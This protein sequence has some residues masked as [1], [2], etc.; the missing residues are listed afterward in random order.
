V[1]IVVKVTL[2]RPAFHGMTRHGGVQW[3]PDPVR[4]LGALKSGAHALDASAPASAAHDVLN[5]L[6]EAPPPTITAP[7]HVLLDHPATYTDRTGLPERLSSTYEEKA[8]RLLTLAPFNMDSF[9]RDAKPRDGVALAGHT[10]EFAI[11]VDL[12]PDEVEALDLAARQVSYF[13]RSEDAAILEVVAQ[14]H[15][16]AGGDTSGVT[17]HPSFDSGGTSRGWQRNTIAWLDENHARVFSDDPAISSLPALP[18]TGY[19]TPLTYSTASAQT[20]QPALAIVRLPSSLPQHQTP[21]LLSGLL[22]QVPSTCRLVPLTASSH[23]NSD[24]RLVG[25]GIHTQDVAAEGDAARL[26]TKLRDALGA[27]PEDQRRLASLEPGTWTGPAR[28]WTSTTP[29]RGF[30]QLLVLEHALRREAQQRFGIDVEIVAASTH[31]QTPREHRW[32]NSSYTDGLGLWWV[33]VA[34]AESIAGPLQLGVSTEHGFGTFL[35]VMQQE[36]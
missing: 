28:R 24:G 32:A 34:F 4:L 1:G 10:L 17:W 13:G 3:P 12:T 6:V 16:S 7:Q 18:P 25:V 20:D 5:R 30:P 2:V 11:D 8:S 21:R 31:T 23:P 9:N 29:L 22:S 15:G 36:R 19:V 35:P 33:T 26:A 27:P 14:S